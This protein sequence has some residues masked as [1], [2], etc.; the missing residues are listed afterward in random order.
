LLEPSAQ[1]DAG[2]DIT[3]RTCC[4]DCDLH[5]APFS[6]VEVMDSR[7]TLGRPKYFGLSTLVPMLN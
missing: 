1:N 7:T 3:T 5:L 6:L 4:K 2:L